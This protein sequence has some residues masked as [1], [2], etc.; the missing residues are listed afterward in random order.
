MIS[1]AVGAALLTA[2]PVTAVETFPVDVGLTQNVTA[3]VKC[4]DNVYWE[5]QGDKLIITGIR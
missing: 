1:A 4:G 2:L 3:S 5:I